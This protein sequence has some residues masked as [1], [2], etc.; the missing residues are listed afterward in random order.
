M[1]VIPFQRTR[2]ELDSKAAQTL[3][4][5]GSPTLNEAA[6]DCTVALTDR[7]IACLASARS[8]RAVRQY[9]AKR[10]SELQAAQAKEN[11]A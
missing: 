10:V 8:L 4:D 11:Q 5:S 6:G 3:R 2:K 7:E 1:G 9:T